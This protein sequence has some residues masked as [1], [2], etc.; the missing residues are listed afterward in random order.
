M[1]SLGYKWQR[2]RVGAK[3]SSPYCDSKSIFPSLSSHGSGEEAS[4]LLPCVIPA[5]GRAIVADG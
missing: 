2:H 5:N 3:L 4:S 1:D